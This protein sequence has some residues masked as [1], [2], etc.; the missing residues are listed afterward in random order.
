M[1]IREAT[2]AAEVE[3]AL[4]QVETWFDLDLK[5]SVEGDNFPTRRLALRAAGHPSQLTLLSGTFT[6][7]PV[8]TGY[9]LVRRSD[10]RFLWLHAHPLSFVADAQALLSDAQA[11]LGM[12]P[13][14][15]VRNPVVRDLLLLAGMEL[16][17]GKDQYPPQTVLQYAGS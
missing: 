6:N 11:K 12:Q 3:E 15:V 17:P 14:G 1:A 9:A 10:A 13:W 8:V 5:C 2:T 16:W 7:P 4:N